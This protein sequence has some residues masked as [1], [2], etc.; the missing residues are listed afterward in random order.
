MSNPLLVF[1]PDSEALL[2]PKINPAGS[3]LLLFSKA[4]PACS[5]DDE[6]SDPKGKAH[7]DSDDEDGDFG[8][9][10][11]EAKLKHGDRV[12]FRHGDVEGEGEIVASGPD[13]V[14]VRDDEGREHK[15][16]HEYLILDEDGNPEDAD[17][18][19]DKDDDKRPVKK[20]EDTGGLT[21]NPILLGVVAG[22]MADGAPSEAPA[23]AESHAGSTEPPTEE[24][25]EE[26]KTEKVALHP[27]NYLHRALRALGLNWK[28]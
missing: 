8:E 2:E 6:G 18:S 28:P 4:K 14:I 16:R 26:P 23:A 15:V 1:R 25:K 7:Q 27:V 10:D 13:G 12:R 21:D 19:S 20:S 11:G 3:M 5:C 17:D 24:V 9:S 22:T